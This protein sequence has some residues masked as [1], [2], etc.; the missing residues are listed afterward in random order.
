MKETYTV[1]GSSRQ[2]TCN[3]RAK[4]SQPSQEEHM[5]CPGRLLPPLPVPQDVPALLRN[6]K[7]SSDCKE[8]QFTCHSYL[9]YLINTTDAVDIT[10]TPM[11]VELRE[12]NVSFTSF[13]LR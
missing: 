12:Q 4:K 2:C 3:S 10:D 13:T 5:F 8:Q 1:L 9:Q 11:Y 7:G 6:K